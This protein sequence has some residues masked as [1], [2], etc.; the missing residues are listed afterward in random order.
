[1]AQEPAAAATLPTSQRGQSSDLPKVAETDVFPLTA[2]SD[3]SFSVS[4]DAVLLPPSVT[5]RIFGKEI[6]DH[7]AVVQLTVSNHNPGAALILQSVLLDYSDWLLSGSFQAHHSQQSANDHYQ[8]PNLPSQVASTEARLVRGELQDAQLWTARNAFIRAATLV[9]AVASGYQFLASSSN[10][11]SGIDAYGNQ[12]V[13]ALATF[14]PDRTQ[15]QINRVSDFGF[16]TNHVIAKSSSDIV[17]AF[18]P[19]DRFLIPSLKKQFLK[20]PAIFFVPGQML[21][22]P[23]LSSY[24]H[25]IMLSAGALDKDDPKEMLIKTIAADQAGT[26]FPSNSKEERI[27]NLLDKISLNNIRVVV[28]GVMTVDTNAVPALLDSVSFLGTPTW[29][30]DSIVTGTITGSFLSDG[31]PSVLDSAGSP[32]GDI[33]IDPKKSDDKHLAFSLKLAKD[34]GSE[35][36]L[37]F[38]VE[39]VS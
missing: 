9:G 21:L 17:V 39:R 8:R 20:S 31:T 18:F 15:L 10:Y 3:V 16:Q 38:L 6:S 7:Y 19:I 34:I 30:K 11:L 26:I 24:L 4:V 13:P 25:E 29:K 27:V 33:T 22:D 28:G 23:K 5:K 2:V 1:V 35:V 37:E 32:V 14:W 12:V 36:K